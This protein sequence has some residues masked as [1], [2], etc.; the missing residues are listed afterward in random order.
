MALRL[1]A[2]LNGQLHPLRPLRERAVVYPHP[3]VAEHVV[4]S[5]IHVARL[6]SAVAVGDDRLVRND[7]L[8]RVARMELVAALPH[9]GEVHRAQ[10]ALPEMVDRPGDVP[11]PKLRAR[12]ARVLVRVARI[13][14]DDAAVAQRCPHFIDR[15]PIGSES[16]GRE[17]RRV[18]G[19]VA[20]RD[21]AVLDAPLA[22]S[23]VEQSDRR[24]A[25]TM[26]DPRDIGRI[27]VPGL[28][29][30]VNDHRAIQTDTEPGE[31]RRIGREAEDLVG[32]PALGGAQLLDIQVDRP[33]N[34]P[35]EIEGIVVARVD[36]G[37]AGIALGEER[38]E[39]AGGDQARRRP[40]QGKPDEHHGQG[41]SPIISFSTSRYTRFAL[42]R[43]RDRR[44]TGR[45]SSAGGSESSAPLKERCRSMAPRIAARSR[46]MWSRVRS[47]SARGTA[48]IAPWPGTTIRG[49]SA[50]GV[51]SA[52]RSPF[53]PPSTTIV[54]PSSMSKSPAN[55]TRSAGSHT[56]RSPAV[57]A[58]PRQACA[59]TIT[60]PPSRR[61]SPATTARSGTSA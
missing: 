54:T 45:P 40:E 13:D 17:R 48:G 50:R 29:G 34:V 57:W 8:R 59:I 37:D 38:G 47:I 14:D 23:T 44:D 41:S 42:R 53:P 15:R 32:N 35:L 2:G 12:A 46:T 60:F 25:Q 10:V 30:A 24:M 5:E 9:G 19:G 55:S 26:Q 3:W 28:S 16:G 52:A 11:A 33:R 22:E 20:S 61:V 39:L 7:A 49:A 51:S 31:E 27:D 21:G 18:D 43:S 1:I 36:H 6:E 56:I 4:Q 58:G